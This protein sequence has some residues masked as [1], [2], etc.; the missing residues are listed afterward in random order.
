MPARQREPRYPLGRGHG[1]RR[2]LAYG[3]TKRVAQAPESLD[4]V[5]HGGLSWNLPVFY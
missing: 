5:G 3:A 4:D 2:Q 1:F